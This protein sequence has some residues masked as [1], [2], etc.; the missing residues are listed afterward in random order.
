[1]SIDKNKRTRSDS[2]FF[3][4]IKNNKRF[5]IKQIETLKISVNIFIIIYFKGNY[6]YELKKNNYYKY[7]VSI[8]LCLF[9]R[10]NSNGDSFK[11]RNKIRKGSDSC[12]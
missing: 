2:C 11:V 7:L 9:K 3:I 10:T 1:M 6:I 12:F 8:M 5:E 4:C